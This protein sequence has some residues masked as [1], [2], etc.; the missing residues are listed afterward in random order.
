MDTKQRILNQALKAFNKSGYG[1]VNLFELAKSLEMSRGNMT[2]HFKDKEALLK[3]LIDQL[4]EKLTS[5]RVAKSIP[6]FQN[7]HH[8]AQLYYRLQQEYTFIFHDNQVL[9]HPLIAKK[10]KSLCEK[11]IKDIETAI[12]FSIQLGNMKVE[13]APG[14]YKNLAITSWMM[15]FFWRSHQMVKQDKTKEDG[16]KVIWSLLLPH[17]TEKGLASFKKFFGEDY[18]TNMGEAFDENMDSYLTF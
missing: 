15:M 4:W 14:V 2:Y 18:L 13:P 8:D 5:G 17:L 9:M 10:M 11:T 12:A 16:E 1:A 3:E 6:S 7:L